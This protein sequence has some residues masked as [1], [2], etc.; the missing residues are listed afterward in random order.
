[1]CCDGVDQGN[2]L[3]DIVAVLDDVTK[4]KIKDLGGLH[5]IYFSHPHYYGANSPATVLTWQTQRQY[6][7]WL[8]HHDW[9]RWVTDPANITHH[10]EASPFRII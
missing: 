4:Q 1:M 5:A 9:Q 2:I 6:H 7:H 10:K 3:F 8:M